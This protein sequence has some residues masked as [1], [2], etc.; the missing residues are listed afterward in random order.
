MRLVLIP[1]LLA[2]SAP[3]FAQPSGPGAALPP[4]VVAEGTASVSVAPD[5]AVIRFGVQ[6]QD[7]TAQKAQ[8]AVNA[9]MQKILTALRRLDVPANRIT[10]ARIDLFPV[11]AQQRPNEYDQAPKLAGFRAS[12]TVR[13]EL[14]LG[15][16]GPE[17]GSVLDAAIGAGANSVEGISFELADDTQPRSKALRTAAENAR[18]KAGAIAD[19]LGSRLGE[20]REASEG[21][22]EVGPIQP[23]AKME[24]RASS[25]P[26]QVEAGE[27]RVS[28][29]VRVR[30]AIEPKGK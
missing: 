4:Y 17:I 9:A 6:H 28:A 30:Y 26:T 5:R 23:F 8:G 21:G 25:A 20:L 13:V 19:A 12:N 24:M 11:Y 2:V 16:K 1:L 14:D 29:T 27:I 10:T 18:A 7:A 22:V 3:A 15:G